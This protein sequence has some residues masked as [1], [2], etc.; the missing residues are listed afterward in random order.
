MKRP[1]HD[2]TLCSNNFC[3]CL[4]CFPVCFDV[5][6]SGCRAESGGQSRQEIQGK[7]ED[8]PSPA[9]FEKVECFL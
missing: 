1:G 8:L 5:K 7:V 6:T 9:V 4:C 2:N 3:M